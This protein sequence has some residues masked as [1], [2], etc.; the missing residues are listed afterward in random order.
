MRGSAE[1]VPLRLDSGRKSR[2]HCWHLQYCIHLCGRKGVVMRRLSFLFS[3]LF[4]IT[5]SL[6]AQ[7][8]DSELLAGMK[9]RSIGPAVMSGRITSID[10][11]VANPDI[12]YVGAATGG[13]W[14]S[15]NGGLTW[16][17]IF[18]DQSVH[19]IG[20]LAVF[21]PSPDVVWVG[22]GEGNA[23]NSVSFGNGIYKSVDGG[24]NWTHL[25][26][27]ATERIYRIR[28]HPNDPDVA[29]VCAMGQLWGENR[30][31]GVY[32]TTD[33]GQTW[34]QILSVDEKTGCADLAMDP[35]NPQKL[36]A[37]MWQ[38]RRWPW[39]FKSGGPGSGLYI[40]HDGGA[41]WKRYTEQDGLPGG[42]LGRMGVDFSRSNPEIVYAL[43]EAEKSALLRSEDGGRSWQKVN[44]SARIAPRPFYYADIR[45]DPAWPNRVYNI[46]GRVAVSDDGGKT[47]RRLIPRVIHGDHHALWIHP[48]DP[49]FLID[50]NDA[51]LAVSRDH[52][53]TWHFVG[54]LPL[55]QYYHLRVDNDTPYNIYGGLQDNGSWRGPSSV[56]ERNGILNR[57]WQ[58]VGSGDGFDTAPFPDDSM[59]GYAMSQRGFLFRWNLRTGGKDI[60]PSGPDDTELRFNWNAGFAQDPFDLATIYY[61]SQFVHKSTDRGDSWEII[62][63]DLTTNNPEWQ[64]QAETGGLTPDVTGAENFT[65][66]ISI[67]PSPV[68]RGVLW[69]GTDDGR[70]HVTRD[71]GQSW[72]SVEKNVRDVPANTWIPHIEPSRLDAGTAY[73]V[74]DD[75]RRSN[76]A[77]YVFKTTDYG[78]SW[79]SLATDNIRSYALAIAEDPVKR[80]LLFL[81]TETGLYVSLNGGRNWFQWKHGFP[82]ASAMDLVVHPREHDLVVG[83]HGRG[84]YILD[85]IRPLRE[86]SAKV[87]EKKIHLFPIPNAQQY[88][89]AVTRGDRA[90][91]H[92]NFQGEN[93]PY[94]A[95]VTF[96]VNFD[97]LPHP[98]NFKEARPGQHGGDGQPQVMVEI[99][100]PGGKIIRTFKERIHQGVNRIVWNLRRDGFK[101]P[102]TE[103]Q[104][105]GVTPPGP[106]VLPGDYGVRIRYKDATAEG[107]VRVLADPRFNLSAADRQAKMDILLSAGGLQETVTEAVNRVRDTRSAIDIVLNKINQKDGEEEKKALQELKKAAREVKKALDETERK[108]WIPPDTKGIPHRDDLRSRVGYVLRSLGSSWDKPTSAQLAYLR[109]AREEA[110]RRLEKVNQ[111]F[112]GP[113]EDFRRQVKEAGIEL[114]PEREPLIVK[115]Q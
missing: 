73:V 67:A 71:G 84:V 22:T 41:N 92:G 61:G 99:T 18:D 110:A 89:V 10:A 86:L 14:K 63:P 42:E 51:G 95:L 106:E 76:Y 111:L 27:E 12:I 13:V 4:V 78:R 5:I 60:R 64:K 26:L 85:D 56:W 65:S 28:L 30:E 34:K 7:Q 1:S 11:V 102:R 94:G 109:Q 93:R 103:E 74:F 108:L 97:D 15:A 6:S 31:R 58:V 50:G 44:E 38:F 33:G 9:A 2:Q 8:I 25:G 16:K 81:G 49:T 75:H 39:F 98:K 40:T 105:P 23:R 59:Q 57:H 104:Q 96:S 62:S 90:A 69:V 43:G 21:Q 82:T 87:L 17:P 36:I 100:D 46:H 80:D 54:N 55:A 32:Q 72:Q 48:D 20:A 77:T 112:T 113:V 45:V 114:L 115:N 47:F 52:G 35:S 53:E 101:R 79:Q 88:Q 29:Y 19:S 24:A 66:I 107:R 68:E 91:G 37:A 70:L 83:T 3:I